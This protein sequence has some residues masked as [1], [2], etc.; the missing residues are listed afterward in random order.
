MHNDTTYSIFEDEFKHYVALFAG[1]PE[2]YAAI[3]SV[4]SGSVHAR[5]SVVW[6]EGHIA[7]GASPHN[8]VAAATS[9]SSEI[10]VASSLLS[11]QSI[12]SHTIVFIPNYSTASVETVEYQTTLLS[13][14]VLQ[15]PCFPGV[16]CDVNSSA[17]G[18]FAC[19]PCPRGFE[20]DGVQCADVDE[21]AAGMHPTE[22]G[23]F[24]TCNHSRVC[25]NLPGGFECSWCPAGYLTSHTAGGRTVC[26][27]ED[28]CQVAN[29]GCDFLTECIN[30]P[31]GSSCSPC[32]EG[33]SGTGDVACVDVDNCAQEDRGGCAPQSRCKNLPGSSACGPCEPWDQ[34]K[35]DGYECRVSRTCA[36]DNGGCDPL[37]ECTPSEEPS[38]GVQCGDCPKGMKGDGDTSCVDYDSCAAAPC[39]EGVPCVDISSPGTGAVCEDCP[40]GYV[41]NG[42]VC[43]LDVCAREPFPCSW[44]PPV[45][46]STIPGGAYSCGECPQGFTGDGTVCTDVDECVANNGGCD[47]LTVCLNHAGG[48]TC[49]ACPEGHSGNGDTRCLPQTHCEENNGGCDRM[50]TCTNSSSGASLCG[51][52][53]AGYEGNGTVGCT[54]IDGCKESTC[55]PGVHCE[56]IPAPGEDGVHAAGHICGAC[57]VSMAGDGVTCVDNPC[58]W[59]NGGCDPGV[60]CVANGSHAAGRFCGACPAGYTD[61]FT[62]GDGTRCEPVDGCRNNPCPDHQRCSDLPAEGELALG[63]AYTCSPCPAGFR[64]V[65]TGCED[66]DEC[67]EDN[68]GCWRSA[69]G[70]AWRECINTPGGS[71]CGSCPPAMRGSQLN[72][73]SPISDC[74]EN[75]GGCWVG[76]GT[77]NGSSV[78]CTQTELG[79][80]CGECPAGFEGDGGASGCSDVDGCALEPCFPG[81][82]CTDVPAPNVGFTCGECPEGYHGDGEEC[83]LCRMLVSIAYTTAVQGKVVRAGWQRGERELIGGKNYGLNNISCTNTKGFRFS[84]RAASSEGMVLTLDA[85]RNKADTYTLNVPKADLVVGRT[86]SFQLEAWMEAN[87]L[88][89][90]AA[91]TEFFV[92]SRPL[93]VVVQGGEVLT[94][95]GSPITLNASDSLD[96]DGEGGKIDFTWRCFVEASAGEPCRYVN[97]TLLAPELRGEAVTLVMQG[98]LPPMN[99]TFL[100]SGRKGPRRTEVSCRMSIT[101]GMP[102]VA[103]IKPLITKANAGDKLR[104]RGK[105]TAVDVPALTY[106]WSML[107]DYST[108]PLDLT[109]NPDAVLASTSRFEPNLVLKPYVLEPGG[110][111]T[112][113]LAAR[114]TMGVGTVAYSVQ[115]NL[116]PRGGR[117]QVTPDA[118]LAYLQHFVLA[119]PDWWDEDIPLWYQF[120][121]SVETT[122]V[123]LGSRNLPVV[124]VDY[125]PLAG[126]AFR[127][128]TMIPM[129]GLP[130][131]GFQVTVEVNVR[132]SLGAVAQAT[133]NLTAKPPFD[134]AKGITRPSVAE[135]LA[136]GADQSLLNGDVQQALVKVDAVVAVL[137]HPA[138]AD[139]S[140][141]RSLPVDS[142][143]ATTTSVMS[144][145]RSK[146]LDT[147]AVVEEMLFPT[148]SSVQR[149]AASIQKLTS[150]AEELS[151]TEQ[152]QSMALLD[153]LVGDTL[154]DPV[155]LQL[156][157]SAAQAVCTGLAAVIA[158]RN[159]TRS[160]EVA[161][162]M[163]QMAQS[164]LYDNV[165]GEEGAEVVADELAMRVQRNAGSNP[166]SA[167]YAFPVATAGAAVRLPSAL[168]SQLAAP[169]P[170]MNGGEAREP[171]H[172]E[173]EVMEVDTRVVVSATDPHDPVSPTNLTAAVMFG[174]V[175]TI[176]MSG[177][178]GEEEVRVQSLREAVLISLRLRQSAA[179]P[180]DRLSL[181][182]GTVRCAF[183]SEVLGAYSMEGCTQFPNP[184][185]ASAELYWRSR[186]LS[187]L[188]AGLESAWALILGGN[189]LTDGCVESFNATWP[190]Y[191]GKDAGLRKYLPQQATAADGRGRCELGRP[192]NFWGCWW[193]WTHQI[194]SGPEC[195]LADQQ[196]FCTHL[197]DFRLVHDQRVASVEP[198]SIR[199][200]DR[201][202]LTRLSAEDVAKST[203]LLSVVFTIM[204]V[205]MFLSWLSSYKHYQER[206]MLL[207][208]LSRPTGT[209]NRGFNTTIG[210]WTWSLFEE[211][212]NQKVKCTSLKSVHLNRHRVSRRESLTTDDVQESMRRLKS[213]LNVEPLVSNLEVRA[214]SGEGELINNLGP[215]ENSLSPFP[216]HG[217]TWHFDETV[218]PQACALQ[219]VAEEMEP[220]P[221]SLTEFGFP[222]LGHE[223][224]QWAV[225]DKLLLEGMEA[226]QGYQVAVPSRATAH[227]LFRGANIRGSNKRRT[228]M[229][230][231]T[232]DMNDDDGPAAQP[233]DPGPSFAQGDVHTRE[234]KSF[235]QGLRRSYAESDGR[236]ERALNPSLEDCPN[237]EHSPTDGSRVVLEVEE[238]REKRLASSSG[239]QPQQRPV[240]GPVLEHV[241]NAAESA[242]ASVS[243]D[244]AEP[245]QTLFELQQAD[246]LCRHGRRAAPWEAKEDLN[247]D[248]NEK[249]GGQ[250]G[251]NASVASEALPVYH[252]ELS[253]GRVKMLPP[254]LT[255]HS[256]RRG[257][258]SKLPQPRKSQSLGLAASGYAGFPSQKHFWGAES[259]RWASSH[260][261]PLQKDTE[262]AEAA[263]WVMQ[264]RRSAARKLPRPNRSKRMIRTTAEIAQDAEDLQ[265]ATNAPDAAAYTWQEDDGSLPSV[266]T[267]AD[268]DCRMGDAAWAA[269][270]CDPGFQIPIISTA[271]A[272][273]LNVRHAGEESFPSNPPDSVLAIDKKLVP[274]ST[275]GPGV[276]ARSVLGR[277]AQ[278][279]RHIAN[280]LQPNL[281]GDHEAGKELWLL[282]SENSQLLPPRDPTLMGRLRFRLKIMSIMVKL[283]QEVQDLNQSR[284][285]CSLLNL[286]FTIM[287]LR[288]P[289]AAL[290]MMAQKEAMQSSYR[291]G[292][293]SDEHTPTEA[294][295]PQERM[296]GTAMVLAYLEVTRTVKAEQISAQVR[297]LEEVKWEETGKSF[298]WMMSVFRVMMLRHVQRRDKE[299]WLRCT[300]LWNLLFLQQ[301][302]GSFLLTESLATLLHAGDTGEIVHLNPFKTLNISQLEATTPAELLAASPSGEDAYMLWATACVLVKCHTLPAM[303][304]YNPQ[305]LPMA[306]TTIATKAEAFLR[307]NV[308]DLKLPPDYLDELLETATSQVDKWHN[309]YITV[310][311]TLRWTAEV[312]SVVHQTVAPRFQEAPTS[313]R[314]R[315]LEMISNLKDSLVGVLYNHPWLR[316]CVVGRHEPFSRSQQILAQCTTLFMQLLVVLAFF[317][318]KVSSCCMEFR[319]AVGCSGD[320]AEPC[321]DHTGCSTLMESE[322]FYCDTDLS[323]PRHP[324]LLPD[325]YTCDHFPQ[326]NIQDQCWAALLAILIIIPTKIGFALLFITGGTYH[327]PKHWTT[328]IGMAGE[329]LSK[330]VIRRWA[331]QAVPLY[332]LIMNYLNI[333]H[334]LAPYFRWILFYVQ[335]TYALVTWAYIMLRV[336]FR[337]ACWLGWYFNQTRVL[338]RDP[339]AVFADL[340]MQDVL[341]EQAL[342]KEVQ[343]DM[344]YSPPEEIDS[345]AQQVCYMLLFL[346]WGIIIFVLLVYSTAIRELMGKNAEEHIIKVWILSLLLDN[347][348]MQILKNGL[349]KLWLQMF[350]KRSKG[351]EEEQ[352]MRWFEKYTARKLP[353][354]YTS[355]EYEEDET[356][357]T[358]G[359]AINIM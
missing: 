99:Y 213:K 132:D 160:S 230:R 275:G 359:L 204:G 239:I 54:D 106:E 277:A 203:V 319:V 326:N 80:V 135:L 32:P 228:N 86:Y 48:H 318:S 324:E 337:R 223:E 309:D 189:N 226:E 296:I 289:I 109:S 345:V 351:S 353:A 144:A 111:Y 17:P 184:A 3:R 198:P 240:A 46:C 2:S 20:G 279:V 209:G 98:A 147:V 68:G 260:G 49:G 58:F 129:E 322:P 317:Y 19:G 207:C 261:E 245:A 331:S 65:G 152:L 305:D 104:L 247:G 246:A 16:Q 249:W 43:E 134:A 202:Q 35:G 21:C 128:E 51:D 145:L 171:R 127:V 37:T 77:A 142:G 306:Q 74:W 314:Q 26:L 53:P 121:S 63:A 350:A 12:S 270:M 338:K 83:T 262:Q 293:K 87:P 78:T 169:G 183:W 123:T 140:R 91:Y 238:E 69:E 178:G 156:T 252:L 116:P 39:F 119:A 114:D 233:F 166:E 42:R 66:V 323:C 320:L 205:A 222:R 195:V 185:P 158:N 76:A 159:A 163:T 81:V 92:D 295:Q 101:T 332:I 175:T 164:M 52:C 1:V 258:W 82:E 90:A 154:A 210:T 57:P 149:L 113:Q 93:V 236:A 41:G 234:D 242:R 14:C 89:M 294:R 229:R 191:G 13:P 312:H 342:L 33:Y 328:G 292:R 130:A 36:V 227:A 18:G 75:H 346:F 141:V 325:G 216:V 321:W 212:R 221:E 34:Y 155:A 137:N 4:Y 45:V 206:S 85:S 352:L 299:G 334:L 133:C 24:T 348:A 193:N 237:M 79:S 167:L 231:K 120:A 267:E 281:R 259:R 67:M 336:G 274:A 194:F 192:G 47:H 219:K 211:D 291:D 55:Y 136:A 9:A 341:H 64:T 148:S 302:D 59:G 31:G 280:R 283:L 217:N 95:E 40:E 174:D 25:I 286:N 256:P 313:R 265:N 354:M 287:Q 180:E 264:V 168:A 61:E 108:H 96:P 200:V 125:T 199:L 329:Y 102:P 6:T 276:Q 235:R 255:S 288:V 218:L 179:G 182:E 139:Q 5:I 357:E 343:A 282:D 272:I 88:V 250:S 70:D 241:C 316:I 151:D 22:L 107:P 214:P 273:N 243:V 208:Q 187:E 97:G 181:Q 50:V 118:G 62:G 38:G 94:G 115:V 173:E 10:F 110:V 333:G 300:A 257:S 284:H 131:H 263:S 355:G 251:Q 172:A 84:W 161:T 304:V 162:L 253:R 311:A 215:K 60:S 56:D 290:R 29:G 298:R 268:S 303:W 138:N 126:P 244:S 165:A 186:V 327:V 347:A 315:Q 358:G 307:S 220:E 27:D 232:R 266:A 344:M 224:Y 190:E 310:V 176:A 269:K 330:S 197:T 15:E 122:S 153:A 23:S 28:E 196:C 177:T 112:F 8:F 278:S 157:A 71:A 103:Q 11:N 30:N 170:P 100:V 73:C 335:S 339:A 117:V 105:A 301:S 271:E 143:T 72:T 340:H 308:H 201:D 124:L 150:N 146:L 349:L 44:D 225:N 7:A 248:E 356:L 254:A 285:L 188:P 297:Q